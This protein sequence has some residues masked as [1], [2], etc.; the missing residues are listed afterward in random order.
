MSDKI[1]DIRGISTVGSK[2]PQVKSSEVIKE[3]QRL[4]DD[5]SKERTQM[6]WNWRAYYTNYL[7][8]P[9]AKRSN[10]T[11][12]SQ[13]LGGDVDVNWRH[14]IKSPKAYEVVETLTSYFMSAFFPNERWFDLV[15]IE[16]MGVDFNAH[17]E[18]NRKFI[19]NKLDQ[20]MFKSNFRVFLRECC[21]AGTAAL[22]FPWVEDNVRFR[23]LSPFEFL[24]DP[25]AQMAND[26]N[27]IR[28]YELSLPEF[29][30][31]IR[32]DVF[33]LTTEKEV[34]TMMS[35]AISPTHDFRIDKD[36]F[37]SVSSL[38]GLSH[39]PRTSSE[40]R[41]V[42]IYEF[43][44]DLLLHDVL[45]K[46][47]RA[48]W[49]DQGVLLA[50][51]TN[52]YGSKPFIVGTYLRLS[53]SPYGVGAL[54]PIA[55]Q[56][57]Y[58]DQLT[59]RNADNVA[60]ASDTMLEIVQDGIL[61][62]D[63]I[64]VAPGKKIFVTERDTV[65]PINMNYGGGVTVQELGL[66]DQTMDKAIGTG[67]FI[68]VGNQRQAERVTAAEVQAQRDV[69]GTRLTDVFSELEST[70]L[71]PF[72][73]KFHVY[74]RQFYQD[75][76]LIQMGPVHLNIGPENIDFPFRVKALGAANVADREYNLRQLLD[77]LNI[78][79]QNEMM[80]QMVNWAEV[81]KELTYM[82]NPMIADRIVMS[83]QQ[84]QGAAGPP[85]MAQELNDSA[86]FLGGNAAQG[87]LQAAQ[88]AGTM[89]QLTEQLASSLGL[90]GVPQ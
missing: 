10:L 83:Q 41:F 12:V 72:L 39:N 5:Y 2:S 19:A 14:N 73:E 86:Q 56:I 61:D 79:G 36:T 88:Q 53:Q 60:V 1:L 4:L 11:Y 3:L 90:G 16:P 82:M 77:W 33:N 74:C 81:I 80:A 27:M 49:T 70:V 8:T 25:R 31:L 84:M 76:E 48:S 62:P 37:N 87:A 15:P 54:Q 69:G 29:R 68:G 46:N 64:Y 20:S 55:S 43:W 65:R 51:D 24:L 38:L 59:S 45:L 35:P 75:R 66:M 44:G 85:S 57:F 71:I 58:K 18:I 6:E 30:Q 17:I 89:P 63:D 42:R 52:P 34:E 47:V 78:V 67:P 50:L 23:V 40:G 28:S 13:N 26:A 21:I 32:D 22:M 7:T 9:E